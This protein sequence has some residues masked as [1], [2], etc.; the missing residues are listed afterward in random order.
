MSNNSARPTLK[1]R[2]AR[3][4]FADII[5]RE[6][7][8]AMSARVDDSPGWD[9][10]SGGGPHDRPWSEFR[11]D[12]DDALEAWRK[13]FMVRRIVTLTRSYVVSGGITLTSKHREV[14][15]F[16]RL[17]WNHRKNR[18]ERRLG[19][20]CDELCRA[21]ELFPVLHTNKVDGISYIRFVPASKIREIET[22]ADDYE[23]ELRYGQLQ[24][25]TSELKWW[26][27]PEHPEAI[28][29]TES[30]IPNLPP[31]MLHFPVNK[32][33]GATRGESDLGPIL[34]WALRYANWLEDRVRLNRARTRQAMLDIEIADDSQVDLKKQQLRR[35]EPLRAGVY[36]HGPG[37]KATLHD[38]NIRADEVADDGQALRLAIAAGANTGLHYLG[39]GA[40]TNYA[41]AKEMGEPTAR[42]YTERQ[43]V[44]VE[45][46]FEILTVAH[47]RYL[48]VTGKRPPA[49]E[50]LRL[51]ASVT[52]VARQ[53]NLALAQ[54]AREVVVALTDMKLNGW[55]DDATAIQLAFKF[56]GEAISEEEIGRILDD[57]RRTKDE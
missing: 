31:L 48:V 34:K 24:E 56:A 28:P 12:L 40:A 55:I 30:R 19:P 16:I 8:A 39:E 21:G 7:N 51:S 54:A 32:P 45:L 20:M 3:R 43:K 41:T 37:E 23:K 35:D 1:E 15:R 2:F 17:F 9:A 5:Q 18:M 13:N 14:D 42:F 27:S 29:N 10:L 25:N 38:L 46:L 57:G 49:G 4:L 6:I 44:F 47:K 53:D 22:D 33:I 50:D 52:E 26:L 11:D 36:I